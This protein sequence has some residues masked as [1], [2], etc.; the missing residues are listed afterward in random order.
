M[1]KKSMT[2]QDTFLFSIDI[3]VIIRVDEI[4]YIYR[5]YNKIMQGLLE[6]SN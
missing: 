5:S 3:Q 6:I 2:R 1:T 4:Q